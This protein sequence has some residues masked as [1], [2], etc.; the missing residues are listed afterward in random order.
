MS[1]L[2]DSES[3]VSM[4]VQPINEPSNNNDFEE[5]ESSNNSNSEVRPDHTQ[6]LRKSNRN[7][8]KPDRLD[9]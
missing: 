4:E 7:I 9:L 8:K 5:S 3:N 6:P 1:A 2:K